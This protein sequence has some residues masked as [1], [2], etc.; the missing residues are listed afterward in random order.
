MKF[1]LIVIVVYAAS[2]FGGH[3]IVGEGLHRIRKKCFPNRST[4][5]ESS[6]PATSLV[7][8]VGATERFMATTLVVI[9]P[10]Y[11]LPFVGAWIALKY[12]ANWLPSGTPFAREDSLLA[13]IGTTWS[14]AIAIAVGWLI[15]AAK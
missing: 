13:L 4:D 2:V 12:A 14:I 9:K 5:W 15:N 3:Y 1:W 8:F 6:D 11:L 10:S 7:F